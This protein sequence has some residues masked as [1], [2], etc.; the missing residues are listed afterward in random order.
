MLSSGIEF[1]GDTAVKRKTDLLSW[2]QICKP[3]NEGGLGI[4]ETDHM[5]LAFMMKL[6]WGLMTEHNSLWVQVLKC[7]YFQH[8]NWNLDKKE[9]S[10]L[11]KGIESVWHITA[12]NKLWLI[13]N[14]NSAKFW[15]DRWIPNLPVL[16]KLTNNTLLPDM[17]DLSV[18][19]YV[20]ASG[21]WNWRVLHYFLPHTAFS[22]R[23]QST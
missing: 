15:R 9:S 21:E 17:P 23:V 8:G 13:N 3:K 6:A 19:D 4:R 20:T 14:G 2:N 7:K 5:N 12:E 22:C 11:W 18:K 16:E 10:C 1:G